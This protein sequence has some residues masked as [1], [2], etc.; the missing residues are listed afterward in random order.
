MPIFS[1]TSD[2][3]TKL[4]WS[5]KWKAKAYAFKDKSQLPGPRCIASQHFST[6]ILFFFK[7]EYYLRS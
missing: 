3:T 5:M 7:F 6:K 2:G 1:F 4:K